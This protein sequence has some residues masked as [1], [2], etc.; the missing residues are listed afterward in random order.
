MRDANNIL[1]PRNYARNL[2]P[3]VAFDRK[4]LGQILRI[5]GRMVALGEWR[6]YGI[7]ML[8]DFS[9]FSIYRH[10]SEHPVYKVTKTAGGTNKKDFF[11]VVEM[12]GTILRRG[13]DLTSVLSA[14]E[15]KLFRIVN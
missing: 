3:R 7:A 2:T 5:Y 8:S 1:R 12:N 15:R 9:I 6:D 13:H 11:A 10:A 14:L 4:E